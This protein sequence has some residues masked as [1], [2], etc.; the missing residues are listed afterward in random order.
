MLERGGGKCSL[1]CKYDYKWKV[2]KSGEKWRKV[3][4]RGNWV[5]V[6]LLVRV[7]TN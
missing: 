2:E 3:G 1:A 7:T 4:D 5:N 6:V